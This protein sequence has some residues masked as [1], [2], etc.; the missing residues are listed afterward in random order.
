M[1]HGYYIGV[2]GIGWFH[3]IAFLLQKLS[4]EGKMNNT[5]VVRA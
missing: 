2:S 4:V 5:A 1:D 3:G